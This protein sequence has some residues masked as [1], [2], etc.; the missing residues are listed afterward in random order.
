MDVL[1]NEEISERVTWL[2]DRIIGTSPYDLGYWYPLVFG[3][4]APY[5]EVVLKLIDELARLEN[6]QFECSI[7]CHSWVHRPYHELGWSLYH[8][9]LNM[10]RFKSPACWRTITEPL[11]VKK[12]RN[13][14]P[15]AV[16]NSLRV[17]VLLK[18]GATCRLCG[19][20]PEQGAKLHVDHIIPWSKGGETVLENLQILCDKCN[21]GKSDYV[22]EDRPE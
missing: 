16:K 20:R 6:E 11:V 9:A 19:A 7:E 5:A 13:R 17:R 2:L 21:I 15:R 8:D 12:D 18:G 1:S 22:P 3:E 14:S 4:P 10:V